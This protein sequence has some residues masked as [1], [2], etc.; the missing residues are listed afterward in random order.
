MPSM[1][2]DVIWKVSKPND[3]SARMNN[4]IFG[5]GQEGRGDL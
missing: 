5:K 3:D 2:L 1:S 4:T